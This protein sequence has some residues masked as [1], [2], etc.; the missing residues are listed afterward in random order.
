MKD[1]KFIFLIYF[2]FIFSNCQ[3]LPHKEM[4]KQGWPQSLEKKEK[5]L[6]EMKKIL[7]AK[8]AELKQK[9]I[10]F[11]NEKTKF[12]N[13]IE[14][15][16]GE[17]KILENQIATEKEKLAAKQK[18]L[19]ALQTDFQNYKTE[20]QNNLERLRNSLE[21]KQI[22]LENHQRE[23]LEWEKQQIKKLDQKEELE[24]AYYVISLDFNTTK[25]EQLSFMFRTQEMEKHFF[26]KQK[27][28]CIKIKEEDFPFLEIILIETDKK[29]NFP[30][31]Y[32]VL[33][34]YNSFRTEND[35][36]CEPGNYKI[37]RSKKNNSV[38]YNM[39][40]V[41]QTGGSALALCEKI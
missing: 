30:L 5:E 19:E 32:N 16:Q 11:E 18:E 15:L 8:Q 6:E 10:D 12:Q 34:S 37:I 4:Q 36:S 20:S 17:L 25:Q 23:L 22:A 28:T 29:S 35:N 21:H 40:A 33:C 3:D 1:L 13:K 24:K 38:L 7:E 41:E 14:K 26:F 31:Q 27:G 2:F 9:N 39:E